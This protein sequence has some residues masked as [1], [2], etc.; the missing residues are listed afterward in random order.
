M[1]RID[2]ATADPNANGT[3]KAGF[4]AG[5]PPGTAATRLDKDWFNAVQEEICAVIEGAGTTLVKATKNQLFTAIAGFVS[6]IASVISSR[7]VMAHGIDAT[8][9]DG[10][11]KHGVTGHG[12]ATGSGIVG[13]GGGTSG[14]GVDGAGGA[15]SG[16]GVRG[17][18]VGVG[19]GVK[20]TGGPTG[21]GVIGFGGG[22]G[23]SG[24]EFTGGV[25]NGKG[26]V[27]LGKGTAEGGNFTG[28]NSNGHG[29]DAQGGAG[30]AGHGLVATG[31]A[32]ADGVHANSGTGN[33][34]GLLAIG[35]GNNAAVKGTGGV[36]S[37][38]GVQGVGGASSG[39]GGDFTGG[40]TNGDALHA[41]GT[42]NG[43]A[44]VANA[45]GTAPVGTFTSGFGR[46]LVLDG[47]TNN[48]PALKL[49]GQ[50]GISSAQPG[51]V[52][53]DGTDF[54]CQTAAGTKT[55]TVV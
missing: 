4:R 22:T 6:A 8:A 52:W 27:V 33:G 7:I 48:L 23:G 10:G 54:R 41:T 53:F 12:L 15:S 34:Y 31:G 24:G 9:D 5:A 46:C 13:V 30:G 25:T 55:F 39:V 35:G 17:Q 16:I 47:H 49:V 50:T 18:G 38:P 29:V 51:D 3:G 37:G 28:G 42:G 2:T 36:S 40:A 1:H 45:S 44:I 14:I 11:T 26:V 21:P 19:E 32:S 43:A 20:G